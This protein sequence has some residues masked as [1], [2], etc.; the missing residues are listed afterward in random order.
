MLS[1]RDSQSSNGERCQEF[2]GMN[3]QI[4]SVAHH[5]RAEPLADVP[6]LGEDSHDSDRRRPD[7]AAAVSIVTAER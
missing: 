4:Q 2:S 1:F 5:D 6:E 3:L 7:R